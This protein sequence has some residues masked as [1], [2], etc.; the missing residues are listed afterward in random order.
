MLWASVNRI[1]YF[2]NIGYFQSDSAEESG[3]EKQK[4][5]ISGHF[6]SVSNF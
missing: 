2:F 1:G 5:M 3:E 4:G 6:L